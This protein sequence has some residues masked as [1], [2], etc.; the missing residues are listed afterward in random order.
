MAT[1]AINTGGASALPDLA[2]ILAAIPSLPRPILAS[3]TARMIE[4]MDEMDPDPDL[5]DVEGNGDLVDV[6]G[7]LLPG[8]EPGFG[9]DDDMENE[10]DGWPTQGSQWEPGGA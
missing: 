6:R 5:E 4:R 3:L 7:R 10:N 8:V 9:Q 2:A 1:R